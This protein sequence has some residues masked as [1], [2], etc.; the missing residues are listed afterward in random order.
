VFKGC[1]IHASVKKGL[2]KKY[3]R[4]V[5]LDQWRVIENFSLGQ[6][7]GQFR[8]TDHQFKMAFVNH[9][10][11]SACVSISHD[12]YLTYLR[13]NPSMLVH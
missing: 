10:F 6:G 3:E 12:A 1:K 13:F 5:A 11:F 2:V 9:T 4:H 8:V 7:R